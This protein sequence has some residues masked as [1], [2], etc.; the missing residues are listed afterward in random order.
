MKK[1]KKVHRA[2]AALAVAA[3][4]VAARAASA[5]ASA[6]AVAARAAPAIAS[7]FAAVAMVR[8]LSE[9]ERVEKAK[10]D[11]MK[12]KIA[13][14]K[15]KIEMN[16][17]TIAQTTAAMLKRQAKVVQTIAKKKKAA[18]ARDDA[19]RKRADERIAKKREEKQE[20]QRQ[21]EEKKETLKNAKALPPFTVGCV[22]RKRHG[23]DAGFVG[24]VLAIQAVAGNAEV[25]YEVIVQGTTRQLRR[26]CASNF[27][28][29]HNPH[30]GAGHV[31]PSTTPNAM[32]RPSASEP[33]AAVALAYVIKKTVSMPPL[34][35]F[36]I[37]IALGKPQP[38]MTEM[39]AQQIPADPTLRV[40]ADGRVDFVESYKNNVTHSPA[41]LTAATDAHLPLLAVRVLNS[42][43]GRPPSYPVCVEDVTRFLDLYARVPVSNRL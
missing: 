5:I 40:S 29:V 27:E 17:L 26:Q 37:E 38:P 19:K 15:R 31:R 7:A 21:R 32:A 18:R 34:I 42:R 30:D 16:Q 12:R 35:K 10:I 23:A 6:L 1:T 36:K 41:A 11:A 22:V 2:A 8:Y 9:R 25:K 14:M 4:A 20:K 33:A 28:L 39:L 13:N 43:Y 3:L 24:S